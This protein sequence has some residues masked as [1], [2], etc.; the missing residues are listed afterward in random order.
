MASRG[1]PAA[2]D[3]WDQWVQLEFQEDQDHPD[4]LDQK[5][6]KAT[7]DLVFMEKRV[8]RVTWGSQDPMGSHQIPTVRS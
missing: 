1:L 5:D 2:P 4:P 7:E 6:S 8:K 3:L